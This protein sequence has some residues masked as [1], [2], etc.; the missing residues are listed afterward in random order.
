M[1]TVFGG[2]HIYKG[3]SMREGHKHLKLVESDFDKVVHLLV[4]T[5]V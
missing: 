3:K 2:P 5:L 4:E 1:T